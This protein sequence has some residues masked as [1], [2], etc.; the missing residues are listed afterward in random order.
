MTNPSPRRRAFRSVT[1]EDRIDKDRRD[2]A[3]LGDE[4]MITKKKKSAK[5]NPKKRTKKKATKKKAKKKSTKKGQ[6]RKT[7]RPAY[8]KE[9]PAQK[10]ARIAAVIRSL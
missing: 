3:E 2:G 4:E 10:R 1:E 8:E 6:A 5:K 7:A 9:T